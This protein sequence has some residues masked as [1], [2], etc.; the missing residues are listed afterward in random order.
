MMMIIEALWFGL[1]LPFRIVYWIMCCI[2]ATVGVFL[3]LFFILA[4]ISAF[5]A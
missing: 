3:G 1:T 5:I 2:F 4:I